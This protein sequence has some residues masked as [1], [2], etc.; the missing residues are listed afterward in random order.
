MFELVTIYGGLTAAFVG[1][2]YR[3]A[4]GQS[5]LALCVSR[6]VRPNEALA[7]QTRMGS[8]VQWSQCFAISADDASV[9]AV[10]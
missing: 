10:V 3:G 1:R 9:R 5:R 8:P 2:L 4:H 6:C 7:C